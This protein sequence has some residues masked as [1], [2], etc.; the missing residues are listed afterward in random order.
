MKLHAPILPLAVCL[1]I[2]I[3]LNGFLPAW[4][5]ALGPMALLL[6]VTYFL[7]RWPRW[8][9]AGIHLCALLLGMSIGAL[10]RQTLD[11]SWPDWRIQQ[12]AIVI[13]E[14]VVK[15]KWVVVDVLTIPEQHK[16]RCRI[17]RDSLSEHITIGD[18]ISLSIYIN[19][20]RAWQQGNFSYQRYMECHGFVGE[21]FVNSYQ[22]QW[23]DSVSAYDLSRLQQVRLRFLWWRHQLLKHY[24]QWNINDEAYSVIAAMTLGEKSRLDP[25]LK[26]TYS[27]VG[28]SH[29]LAL[30]GLHLMIIYAVITL[31]VGWR[32][33]QL[34]SQVV[35]VLAVWAFAFLV[36][37][38]PSVTRS[39]FMISTYAILSVGHRDPMSVNTLAFTAV[40]LLI[41]NPY[42][43]YDMGFQ[44]SFMAVLAIQLFNPLFGRLVPPHIL[45]RHHILGSIW[46]LLTVSLSAQM[47][48]APL[49]A[50]Y[51]GRFTPYFLVSNL[52]V[53][54]LATIVL[55][56]TL[57]CLA[58]SAW[59]LAM[60]YTTKLL[61]WTTTTMNSLLGYIAGWP[62]CSIEGIY[63]SMPQV[64]CLYTMIGAL[65]TLMV[66]KFRRSRRNE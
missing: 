24:R 54:P 3:V 45:Q 38:S 2:G 62:S 4:Y 5:M 15:Q 14:P 65:W 56:L 1:M 10:R 43:L 40:V 53:V 13:S 39:A 60:I 21:A 58:V 6:A 7:D 49:I 63:I 36:G 17:A 41:V 28:A 26:D 59:P 46:G 35:I 25:Q 34:L 9:T 50:Y 44:L 32:R 33:F 22:W 18:G 55:Y 48:T 8:Q 37:L 31:F 64:F 42:A 12:E 61:G 66:L 52:I 23:N 27:R 20:V 19:K 29:I 11:V 47:G 51:F 16:L 57:V 30:S